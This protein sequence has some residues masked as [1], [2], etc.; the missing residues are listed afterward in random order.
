MIFYGLVAAGAA[1]AAYYWWGGIA[2]YILLGVALVVGYWSVA[3]WR[4]T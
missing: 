4:K 3:L 1:V 2:A